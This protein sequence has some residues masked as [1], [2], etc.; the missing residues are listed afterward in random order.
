VIK[1]PFE[2][3][4][5]S[6]FNLPDVLGQMLGERLGRITNTKY[7]NGTGAATP[8]GIVV[9]SSLGKTTAGATAI[10]ADEI[11]DLIHSVDPAYR[12]DSSFMMHDNILLYIRKL[13]SSD[14]QYIWQE[15]LSQGVP[16]RIFSYM[17]TINQDMQSSVATATKTMLFGQMKKYKIR[18]VNGVRMI[19]LDERYADTDE[20]AF[21]SLIR[22]DG[23]MLDAGTAPIKHMLQA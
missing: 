20:I 10:T 21:L 3:L 11:L 12:T 9:A 4:E 15:G 19:R 23:N 16:D 13:K 7:T 5:D 1:V 22:E 2:L 17:L 8:K 14:N 18:T 6:V